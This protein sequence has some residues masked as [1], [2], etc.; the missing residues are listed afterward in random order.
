MAEPCTHCGSDDTYHS[1]HNEWSC[2]DCGA[3]F[4]VSDRDSL[5]E[6]G[7]WYDASQEP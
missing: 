2:G 1:T 6:S 5:D 4:L 7:V 3:V